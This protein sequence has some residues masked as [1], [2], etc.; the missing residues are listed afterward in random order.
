MRYFERWKSTFFV[1][2]EIPTLIKGE[3]LRTRTFRKPKVIKQ[4]RQTI[5]ISKE[6][7]LHDSTS[8]TPV[9]AL[10][11]FFRA[12][13]QFLM[14][15]PCSEARISSRARLSN[16]LCSCW[17]LPGKHPQ[18]NPFCLSVSSQ[19]RA[20]AEDTMERLPGH[21]QEGPPSLEVQGSPQLILLSIHLFYFIINPNHLQMFE[22]R[23]CS[24]HSDIPLHLSSLCAPTWSQ[25]RIPKSGWDSAKPWEAHPMRM[26]GDTSTPPQEQQ[27]TSHHVP[28]FAGEMSYWLFGHLQTSIIHCYRL[29]AAR[30][31][32]ST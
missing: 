24:C 4:I 30:Q 19:D 9:A 16:K 14:A 13:L 7:V 28:V 15:T 12:E 31:Q 11:Y 21:F 27:S 25:H 22:Y 1:N 10:Q 20:H 32:L 5:F 17:G 3:K 8:N 29:R 26:F 2:A 23:W 18:K 6:F